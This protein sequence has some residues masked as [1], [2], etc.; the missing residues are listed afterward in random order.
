[1]SYELYFLSREAHSYDAFAEHFAGRAHYDVQDT[2]AWYENANTG[3]Y[4][5]FDLPDD[6]DS[7]EDEDALPEHWASFNLNYFRPH[8]FADE[9]AIELACFAERFGDG[10]FDPQEG[11][12]DA[13]FTIEAFLRGWQRGNRSA[14]RALASTGSSSTPAVLPADQLHRAWE[15]NYEREYRQEELGD[16][17]FVPQIG[18]VRSAGQVS[19]GTVWS[20]GIPVLLPETDV[21][22]I[23]RDALAPRKWLRRKSGAA[24]ASWDAIEGVVGRYRIGCKPMTH[25]VLD[26]RRTPAKIAEWVQSLPVAD[27]LEFV[28]MDE[29]LDAETVDGV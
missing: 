7:S 17:I 14:Y 16:R 1:M 26:Y 8:Y 4:F 19:T 28:A 20:D 5:S 29:I 6:E 13:V 23:Y 2:R 11:M 21:V 18:F 27:S 9:A 10:I 12:D 3:V 24:I 25:Y 15:W 22:V